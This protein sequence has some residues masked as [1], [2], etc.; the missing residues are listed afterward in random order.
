[1][2]QYETG[3][4]TPGFE[5]LEK[6]ADVLNVP[7]AYFYAKDDM[8]VELIS[9]YGKLSANTQRDIFNCVKKLFK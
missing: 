1:M 5:V 9:R 2:N 3:K 4:H 7:T 6:I 8:L